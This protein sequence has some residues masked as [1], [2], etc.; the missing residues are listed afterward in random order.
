MKFLFEKFIAPINIGR[1]GSGEIAAIGIIIFP[2]LFVSCVIFA[3][4][5]LEAVS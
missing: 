5:F 3:V 1:Y 2:Y 4:A